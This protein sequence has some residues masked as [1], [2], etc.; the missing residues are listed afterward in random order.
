M[1]GDNMKHTKEK[2]LSAGARL[3]WQKGFNAT[4]LQEILKE[5]GVP[6]GS[7]YF[8]FESKES[9]GLELIDVYISFFEREL[10]GIMMDRTKEG[11]VRIKAFLDFFRIVLEKENYTGGCPLGNLALEMGD[12]NEKFGDRIAQGFEEIES[13]ILGCLNDAKKS[14][15]VPKSVNAESA[16][17]FILNSWEGALV[18][19]KVDKSLKPLDLLEDFIFKKILK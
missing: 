7:F 10:D 17:S 4:G 11:I 16:A 5:A 18:R 1:L 13:K 2:I 3:V 9:F 19:V 14:G 12:I 8:Y 6:K 15:D